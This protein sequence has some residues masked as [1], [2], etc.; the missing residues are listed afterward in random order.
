MLH[1]ISLLLALSML[2]T[3]CAPVLYTPPAPQVPILQAKG[4]LET[5]FSVGIRGYSGQAAYA[6]TDKIGIMLDGRWQDFS[7]KA[8]DIRFEN[9]SISFDDV[10]SRQYR[11]QG[12]SAGIGTYGNLG[13]KK[14]G[15]WGLYGGAGV[16]RSKDMPLSG[17][18]FSASNTKYYQFFLQPQIGFSIKYIEGSIS[19]R[20]NYARVGQVHS[21]DLNYDGKYF[22]LFTLE[23]TATLAFGYDPIKLFSQVGLTFGNAAFQETSSVF[24]GSINVH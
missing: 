6:I 22:D 15:C 13:N 4:E 5:R 12:F 19:G 10:S 18:F 23:P 7:Q 20:L 17:T 2:L 8:T 24:T 3:N 9:Y 1:K 16:G 14:I 11:E 21:D